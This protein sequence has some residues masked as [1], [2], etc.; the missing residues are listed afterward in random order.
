MTHTLLKFCVLL[1]AAV[2]LSQD[3][4]PA[5]VDFPT[6]Q[7]ASIENLKLKTEGHVKVWGLD[8]ITRWDLN[9]GDGQL[10]FT[11]PDGFEAAAPAQIIGTYNTKDHTWLWSWANSSIEEKLQDDSRKLRKFGEDKNIERL[12]TAKWVG[13][14]EDAWSMAAL[15]VMLC[16]EQGAYRGP[17]GD[18]MVFIAFGEVVLRKK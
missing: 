11:L 17:A 13:K 16:D 8:K 5:L 15:A 6:L 1:V 2:C 3:P 10:I 7:K 4:P 12:R 9:Q 18:T 14:E